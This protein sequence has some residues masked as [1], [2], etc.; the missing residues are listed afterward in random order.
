MK[1]TITLA[2]MLAISPV[3]VLQAHASDEADPVFVFNR[4]CYAQ[5]PDVE[6]IRGMA[7]KLAWRPMGGEDLQRFTS[8]ETPDVLEGWDAQVGE[9]IYRIGLVQSAPAPSMTEAFPEFASGTATSCTMVMDEEHDASTF[10][11]N[12]QTLAGKKPA[13]KDVPEGDL[14]TTT[15]AGGNDQLKVFLFSKASATGKGGLLNVTV[16]AK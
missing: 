15:W 11:A 1:T 9:R 14:R 12:M 13:S 6:A 8:I 4:I 3:L 2:L 10:T 5:V 7:R 16:L